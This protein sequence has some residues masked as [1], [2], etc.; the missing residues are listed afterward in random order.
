MRAVMGDEFLER[1]VE[2]RLVRRFP[3]LGEAALHQQPRAAA[4]E[5]PHARFRHARAPVLRQDHVHGLAK[6]A[7]RVGQ[8]AVEIEE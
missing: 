5:M 7:G 8:R 6:V 1:P 3:R 2:K 4:D